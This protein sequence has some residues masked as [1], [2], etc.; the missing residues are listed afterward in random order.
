MNRRLIC[1]FATS[2]VLTD[3]SNFADSGSIYVGGQTITYTGKTSN[4]LTGIPA[5]G[6]GSVTAI[7]T[8]LDNVWQGASVG[9][10]LYFTVIEG[11]IC[12][13][14]LIASQYVGRAILLDYWIEAPSVDSDGDTLDIYGFRA[15]KYYL[16]WVVRSQLK[17]DGERDESD[18]D[19]KKYLIIT[20]DAIRAEGNH[21]Q[22]FKWQPKL[23]SMNG[24]GSP[25]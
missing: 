2:I 4:T 10:P 17:K 8:T 1:A 6:D 19:Y 13:Y 22:K 5:S 15:V 18:A 20:A 12:F 11:N 9:S 7:L 3:A 16:T 25:N 21:G 24:T 23:N 14:P